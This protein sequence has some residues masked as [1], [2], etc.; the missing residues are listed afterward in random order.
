M[1]KKLLKALLCLCVVMLVMGG[2]ENDSRESS[3]RS[4]RSEQEEDEDEDNDGGLFGDLQLSGQTDEENEKDDAQAD[5][6]SQSSQAEEEK[7][8]DEDS[9]VL[10]SLQSLVRTEEENVEADTQ[11]CID[12][13]SAIAKAMPEVGV[14]NDANLL[15]MVNSME[16]HSNSL[17]TAEGGIA[18]SDIAD[19]PS[20]AFTN[21][22]RSELG[23]ADSS[24]IT[25]YSH[26]DEDT[27]CSVDDIRVAIGNNR[28]YVWI[29]NSDA[30][31]N[32][33][34]SAGNVITAE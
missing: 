22:V 13:R 23:I 15:Q 32:K 21:R 29:V 18:F 9:G 31:G 12:I 5:D 17:Y 4:S 1:K 33:D 25:L 7:E 8:E 20:N 27:V 3:S 30:T 10:E 2:C 16:I 26:S 34:G 24:D 11:L 14:S 6:S 28:A 19:G